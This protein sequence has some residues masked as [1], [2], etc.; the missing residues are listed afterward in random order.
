[1]KTISGKKFIKILE[2]HGWKCV[3]IKGSHH[4]YIKE[5]RQERLSVP[6]H[7]NKNLKIGLSLL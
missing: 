1:M 5:D 2:K 4:I 3:R 6:V 7:S